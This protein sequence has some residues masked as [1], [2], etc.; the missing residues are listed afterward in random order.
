[1]TIL[2]KLIYLFSAIPIELPK[3]FFTELEKTITK[4]IWK[5]K[6]S[7]ISR[8]M[9]KKKIQRKVALQFQISNSIIKEW[10]SKQFRTG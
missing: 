9:M 5:N 10:S 8:E 7:R 1:M 6:G 4:F 3:N 2:P